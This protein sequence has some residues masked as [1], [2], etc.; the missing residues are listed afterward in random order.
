MSIL[1][2]VNVEYNSKEIIQNLVKNTLKMLERRDKIDSWSDTYKSLE[3]VGTKTTYQIMTK[4]KLKTS[5][6][7]ISAKLTSI[8]QGT[9]LDR[10]LSNN[11]DIHKIVICSN[12]SPKKVIKQ[13]TNDY[14]NAEFFF[15]SELLED[16]PSKVFVPVHRIIDE[17]E[18]KELLSKFQESELARIFSTDIMARHLNAQPGDIIHIT[19]PSFTAGQNVFYRRVVQG[20]WDIYF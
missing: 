14:T 1:S 15:E 11:L 17:D 16:I 12:D 18:R 6:N 4:D 19:R 9:D 5:I 13:I 2:S 10:Y 7:Y 8:V 20:T 3:D